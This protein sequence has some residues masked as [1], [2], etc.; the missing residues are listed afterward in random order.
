MISATLRVKIIK[1]KYMYGKRTKIIATISDRNCG[2]ELIRALYMNGMNVVRLNTAHQNLE[3]TLNVIENVRKVSDK[4][5]ILIDTK[6]PEIRT[7]GIE[8]KIKVNSGDILKISN[9]GDVSGDFQT[10]FRDF[11]GEVPLHTSILVDDGLVRLTVIDKNDKILNVRA[12]NSGIIGNKKSINVPGIKITLDTV[13]GKD[14]EYIQF[15]IDNRLDFI[16]HSF[17]RNAADVLKIQALLDERKSRIKIIAKIENREGVD[18]LDE[19][20]DA[21]YGIMIARGDL[22]IEIPAEQV[23][24][25]QKKI[26]NLCMR[27]GKPV[28]TATQMLHSMID[29]PRP[30]RAEVSD[31]A[32][33]VYDGTDAVMLSGETAY[34]SYP[35]ESIKTMYNIIKTIEADTPFFRDLPVFESKNRIRNYLIKSAVEAAAELDIRAIVMDTESG[36][37]ARL[38]SAYRSRT[39]VF[40]KIHEKELVRQLTL[41]YGIYCSYLEMPESTGRLINSAVSSLVEENLIDLDDNIIVLVST[42]GNPV[43]GANVLEINKARLCLSGRKG[44][45]VKR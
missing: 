27:K 39:I 16:A 44:K 29:N 3:G 11:V 4:I 28:I 37:S 8:G 32:A 23:P 19:I 42:P 40:A 17:V 26:I 1:G 2:T 24:G 9:P 45:Y 5:G 14:M 43:F 15:A 34:G 20:L 38:I 7:V 6:G 31:V 33:A 25:I 10:S 13:S 35:V 41:S 21:A 22:G 30:T 18:N 36:L 12:E